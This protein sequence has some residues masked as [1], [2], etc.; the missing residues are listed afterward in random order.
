[1]LFPLVARAGVLAEA[2]AVLAA[3]R[4]G[5]GALVTV[6]GEPGIGKTRLA[7]AVADRARARAGQGEPFEVIWTWCPAAA[8]GAPLRPWSRVIRMLAGGHAAAARLVDG[9]PFLAAL[10]GRAD[11]PPG[12]LPDPEGARSQLSFDLAEVIAAAAARRP[13]LVVI[14]DAHQ[15]DTSSLRLLAEL[16][17][18]LR[19]MPA[20]VLVTARDGDQDWRGRLD[21][22]GA[23]LRS[24]PVITLPP[25]GE[26]D[27]A[28][29]V[30]GVAGT[31]PGP[32]LV[33]IIEGR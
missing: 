16:A 2:D 13:V 24:G 5:R 28:G 18:A 17:P 12:D 31:P 3:A 25:L 19:A 20:A 29:L 33:A 23:L 14:D 26:D 10:A 15:A 27:V 9:S 6:T 11:H 21:E 32:A 30:T 1:M 22:S 8:G 7:E 4:A